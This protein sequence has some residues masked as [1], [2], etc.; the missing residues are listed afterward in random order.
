MCLP[1][2]PNRWRTAIRKDPLE[3][4]HRRHNAAKSGIEDDAMG[5]LMRYA[6]YNPRRER[7]PV[8]FC[9]TDESCAVRAVMRD[10][11]AEI[12][13]RLPVPS[14]VESRGGLVMTSGQFDVRDF[15]LGRSVPL[16]LPQVMAVMHREFA[17]VRLA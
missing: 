13:D 1:P 17:V 2:A 3:A 11:G 16:F 14:S 4:E 8:L 7:L 6:D 12:R 10:P 15:R 9:R 5:M